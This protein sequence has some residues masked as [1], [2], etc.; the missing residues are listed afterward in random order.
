MGELQDLSKIDDRRQRLAWL[1][2]Y[3]R[4]HAYDADG[5]FMLHAELAHDGDREASEA[6]RQRAIAI[7]PDVAMR[8]EPAG[9]GPPAADLP[10]VHGHSVVQLLHAHE[11]ATLYEARDPAGERCILRIMHG[12]SNASTA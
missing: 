5:W 8:F 10:A 2:T 1:R 4:S 6:A 7:D 9:E 11:S 3:V 12:E